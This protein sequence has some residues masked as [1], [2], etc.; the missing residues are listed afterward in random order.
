[1]DIWPILRLSIH[2]RANRTPRVAD[3]VGSTSE[4]Y[5]LLDPEHRRVDWRRTPFIY[6]FFS[7]SKVFELTTDEEKQND[8][9]DGLGMNLRS[10]RPS[11]RTEGITA[12]IAVH[13]YVVIDAIYILEFGFGLEQ[14]S[15]VR[16]L[17][18]GLKKTID[19]RKRNQSC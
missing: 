19:S 3:P 8:Y 4:T 5:G 11:K 2:E 1:M 6:F 17:C 13:T 14:A 7:L 10:W 9:F 16:P 15:V 18:G 12:E